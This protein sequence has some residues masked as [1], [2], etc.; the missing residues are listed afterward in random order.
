MNNEQY[1]KEVQKALEKDTT[2]LGNVYRLVKK[3]KSLTEIAEE[4]NVPNKHVKYFS[5]YQVLVIVKGKIDARPTTARNCVTA[6]R[7]FLKRHRQDFSK[8][9][10]QELTKREQICNKLANHRPAIEKEAAKSDIAGIYV[11]TYPK[12]YC[13]PDVPE[14]NDT[15]AR[16]CLKIGMSE[17][18]TVKRIM[19][20]Q[21]GMPERPKVLQIWVADNDGDLRE[22]E[23]K[24]HDHLRTIGH[25]GRHSKRREWFLT[26]E[27]SIASTANLLGLTCYFN[28]P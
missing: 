14:T 24:I 3:G 21:T 13:Q 11:Y 6:L 25:G 7:G 4:I 17:K 27:Q 19:Q 5:Y 22:I 23:K 10:I 20:Q 1:L 9:T 15:D 12:Y 2:S 16:I 28:R 18:D 8:A 26:N